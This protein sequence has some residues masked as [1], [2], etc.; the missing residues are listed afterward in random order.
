VDFTAGCGYV[1]EKRLELLKSAKKFRQI[2]TRMLINAS[3]PSW[4]KKWNNGETLD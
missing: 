4:L 2:K 3:A 1:I